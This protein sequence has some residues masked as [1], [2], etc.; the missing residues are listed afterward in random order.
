MNDTLNRE[1]IEAALRR[2]GE[3]ADQAG[4]ALKL[5]L[6]GGGAMVWQEVNKDSNVDKQN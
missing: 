3:L 5:Q 2:L 1:E 4:L 6:V